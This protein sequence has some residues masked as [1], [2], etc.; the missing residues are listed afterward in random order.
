MASSATEVGVPQQDLV[1][2]E[3]LPGKE[4]LEGVSKWDAAG[5]PPVKAEVKSSQT[6]P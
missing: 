3:E 1:A 2:L 4:S 6:D 5:C